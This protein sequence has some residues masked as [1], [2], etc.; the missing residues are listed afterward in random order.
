MLS[1]HSLTYI[2][3]PAESNDEKNSEVTGKITRKSEF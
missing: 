3:Q 2:F 1:V